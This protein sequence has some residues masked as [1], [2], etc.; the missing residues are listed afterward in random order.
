HYKNLIDIGLPK[1]HMGYPEGH[2]MYY[3]LQSVKTK[4][5]M[6]KS[7]LDLH[8]I[9]PRLPDGLEAL[10]ALSY[11]KQHGNAPR[12]ADFQN[13]GSY[14][15]DMLQPLRII[16]GLEY[17]SP[18]D[19]W[20]MAIKTTYS[21]SKKLDELTSESM[22]GGF[23][24]IGGSK[25]AIRTPKWT[26]TDVTGFYRFNDH[27]TLRLGA[28]NVFNYRYISWESARQASCDP[29][30]NSVLNTSYLALAAPGR[31]YTLNLEIKY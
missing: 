26:V 21:G 20:G 7:Q 3:N 6:L 4:G 9:W 10:F 1:P 18:N 29:I 19:G 22:T 16:Y 27:M 5:L 31:N 23:K 17:I 2:V 24:Y 30:G 13:S 14:A 15:L 25:T 11:V 12:N 8:R 28:Y